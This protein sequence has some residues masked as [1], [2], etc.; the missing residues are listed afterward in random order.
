ME[1]N[2]IALLSSFVTECCWQLKHLWANM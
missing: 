1:H 2:N